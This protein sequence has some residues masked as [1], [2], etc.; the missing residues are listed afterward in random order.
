MVIVESDKCCFR[1]YNADQK[2]ELAKLLIKLSFF[3]GI[4]EPLSMDDLKMEV[5]FLCTQFPNCTA[6]KLETAFYKV[7]SG[8]LGEIEHF[9]SFSPS[10]IAKVIR[11]YE[12]FSKAAMSKYRRLKEAEEAEL[13]AKE[14]ARQYDPIA[15]FVVTLKAEYERHCKKTLDKFNSFD[16]HLSNWTVQSGQ[17]I[18][19]FTDYDENELYPHKYIS[20]FFIGLRKNNQD[21]AQAIENYVRSNGKN[22]EH[23]QGSE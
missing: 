19:L 11:A 16:E 2:K 14:K 4:K 10:Y 12:S 15:G 23:R 3:V 22:M 5:N 17:K 18:G 20:L 7:S 13:E 9:Q 8:E 21:V 6:T 1:S